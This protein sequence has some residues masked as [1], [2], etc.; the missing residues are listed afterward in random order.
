MI[1]KVIYWLT[2]LTGH[3]MCINQ[4]IERLKF[5]TDSNNLYHYHCRFS[6]SR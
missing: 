2:N 6:K 1:Y 5:N 4:Y 3:C